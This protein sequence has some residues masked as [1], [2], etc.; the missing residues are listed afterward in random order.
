MARSMMRSPV[1]PENS[2]SGSMTTRWAHTDCASSLTSSGST[3]A[4]P[5]AAAQTLTARMSAIA[6]RTDTPR[7]VSF[8]SRVCSESWAT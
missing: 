4:R 5:F 1:T 7:R 2:A 3:N 8:E 6:P